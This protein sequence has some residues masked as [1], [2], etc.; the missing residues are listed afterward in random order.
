MAE[1]RLSLSEAE[2]TGPASKPAS[3]PA[4]TPV[5]APPPKAPREFFPRSPFREIRG[6]QPGP[7]PPGGG[8]IEPSAA[9]RVPGAST[10]HRP[11]EEEVYD[12][13]A[14]TRQVG[15]VGFEKQYEQE[16]NALA[17]HYGPT[18]SP[19]DGMGFVGNGAGFIKA[20]LANYV[21]QVAALEAKARGYRLRGQSALG[22]PIYR[23]SAKPGAFP[24]GSMAPEVDVY[25]GYYVE[26]RKQEMRKRLTGEWRGNFLTGAQAMLQAARAVAGGGRGFEPSQVRTLGGA[27][28]TGF[29]EKLMEETGSVGAM[30]GKL[31][32]EA[33]VTRGLG[34]AFRG[35][36]AARA[37]AA[38]EMK[39]AQALRNLTPAELAQA[40][41]RRRLGEWAFDT[42]SGVFGIYAQERWI[43]PLDTRIRASL[44]MRAKIEN[45]DRH[46]MEAAVSDARRQV[47][48]GAA[49]AYAALAIVSPG[50]AKASEWATS[51]GK[52][53]AYA[54]RTGEAAVLSGGF[55]AW[56]PEVWDLVRQGDW[57]ALTAKF[58]GAGIPFELFG[59]RAAL[60]DIKYQQYRAKEAA[61]LANPRTPEEHAA[62]KAAMES[63]PGASW[64]IT[65][66]LRQEAERR[67][68]EQ[69]EREEGPID[70]QVSAL[71]DAASQR[72]VRDVTRVV[73]S[74]TGVERGTANE[75]VFNVVYWGRA[76]ERA[77]Q[78]GSSKGV[79]ESVSR[80]FDALSSL[81]DLAKKTG[82]NFEPAI[83]AA[84]KVFFPLEQGSLARMDVAQ[85]SR[86]LAGL[87]SEVGSWSGKVGEVITGIRDAMKQPGQREPRLG[88]EE[89]RPTAPR[90]AEEEARFEDAVSDVMGQADVWYGKPEVQK[91]LVEIVQE[92]HKVDQA[93]ARRV[94]DEAADRIAAQRGEEGPTPSERPPAKAPEPAPAP[95]P[96]KAAAT[97]A[98]RIRQALTTAATPGFEAAMREPMTDAEVAARVKAGGGRSMR[99]LLIKPGGKNGPIVR[100]REGEV[101]A[102]ARG[103]E[104][105]RRIREAFGTPVKEGPKPAQV[106][107]PGPAAGTEG[108]LPE[109]GA[110]PG[111]LFAGKAREP[112]KPAGPVETAI[113][114]LA[115]AWGVSDLDT[116]RKFLET[117]DPRTRAAAL[118][119]LFPESVPKKG[120]EEGIAKWVSFVEERTREAR[121]ALGTSELAAEGKAEDVAATI[122][123]R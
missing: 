47:A 77:I 42:A 25:G 104:A 8:G 22:L 73:E 29:T 4:L 95:E 82:T 38:G 33:M 37:A 105:I 35:V 80:F 44:E 65:D 102:E 85:A 54:V 115:K 118:K 78:T 122:A 14:R 21:R 59:L 12:L 1:E 71:V 2:A 109:P 15:V 36:Q 74:M 60:R 89:G 123:A 99:G 32:L 63:K 111:E 11:Y 10:F 5:Q 20:S 81:G 110:K 98:E 96:P 67:A 86:A 18:V 56:D 49:Q 30:A 116:I 114:A 101:W 41:F 87:A 50:F 64:S 93:T 97:L 24:D 57:A 39:T 121:E 9:L 48:L 43:A 16:I 68:N 94:M 84:R 34:R 6:V 107:P 117:K 17:E 51:K 3:R 113:A 103:P 79:A 52:F 19:P 88:E 7:L 23:Y 90:S 31:G 119:K 27:P 106:A 92:A 53:G 66:R 75:P 108:A 46:T 91:G 40:P 28:A 58:L 112:A 76:I 70:A 13:I 26:P 45:W 83:E 62:T 55:M 69:V 100:W 120:G 61:K 72:Q